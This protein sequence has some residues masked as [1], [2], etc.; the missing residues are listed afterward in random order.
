MDPSKD[1]YKVLEVPE[2]ASIADIKKAFHKLA[3]KYH[4]DLHP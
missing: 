3:K 2:S 1:Y 4:P